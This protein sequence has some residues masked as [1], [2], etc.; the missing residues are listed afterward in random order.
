[1]KY[2]D[3]VK[4][5]MSNP[6]WLV[7]LLLTGLCM[8]IPVVGPI[9]VLG[10][11]V[12]VKIFVIQNGYAASY[13]LFDFARFSQYLVKGIWPFLVALVLNL[14]LMPCM[15]CVYLPA[16][17]GPHMTNDPSLGILL[18]CGSAVL[19][20]PLSLLLAIVAMPIMLRAS[21]MQ[22][23]AGAFNFAAVKDFVSRTFMTLV[24]TQLFIMLF[25]LILTPIGLCLCFVGIY[26]AMTYLMLVNWHLWTQIYEQYLSRGGQPIPIKNTAPSAFPV[27]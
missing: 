25:G 22:D 14:V 20:V 12:E 10:Y 21:L 26:P 5:P 7:N 6:K 1:M 18:S 15:M 9:V 23:F 24:V 17:L 8:L 16:I 19:L 13:P 2:M 11:G 27:Q 4:F 3:A